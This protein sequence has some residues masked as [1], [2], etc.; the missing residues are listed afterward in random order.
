MLCTKGVLSVV[1]IAFY[2]VECL[3]LSLLLDAGFLSQ[4]NSQLSHIRRRETSTKCHCKL[5]RFATILKEFLKD[6]DN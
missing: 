6:F 2:F 5:K 4:G 3:M 1:C